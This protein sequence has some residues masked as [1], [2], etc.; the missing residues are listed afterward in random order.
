MLD[1]LVDL[2]LGALDLALDFDVLA[3]HL[4]DDEDNGDTGVVLQLLLGHEHE[5]SSKNGSQE[6]GAAALV[7]AEETLLLPDVPQKHEGAILQW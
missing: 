2:V 6:L 3:T 1:R 4:A 5:T 7:H